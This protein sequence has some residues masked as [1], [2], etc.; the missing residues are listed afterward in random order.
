MADKKTTQWGLQSPDATEGVRLVTVPSWEDA[1]AT[2]YNTSAEICIL[3]IS[4]K[5]IKP[6]EAVAENSVISSRVILVADSYDEHVR[7]WLQKVMPAAILIRPFSEQ[8]LAGLSECI[9]FKASKLG[10]T[11]SSRFV[12]QTMGMADKLLRYSSEGFVLI[13]GQ[14]RTVYANKAF[15]QMLGVTQ[16]EMVGKTPMDFMNPE[17]VDEFQ[18]EFSRRRRGKAFGRYEATLRTRDGNPLEVV[19]NALGIYS[20]KGKYL[21]SFGRISQKGAKLAVPEKKDFSQ[22]SQTKRSLCLL[23]N[24]LL[25]TLLTMKSQERLKSILDFMESFLASE[26]GDNE[27]WHTERIG[28]TKLS[29]NEVALCAMIKSGLTSD[30]IAEIFGISPKTVAFHRGKLR[31]KLGLTKRGEGLAAF[32]KNQG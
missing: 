10:T 30:Q 29:S 3:D 19:I 28:Q 5:T 27:W 9:S 23:L 16:N 2:L 22:L 18:E 13:D 31:Q 17:N 12:N 25:P 21:G 26:D 11:P 4:D 15:A 7:Q 1:I 24:S 14:G 32:L 20:E 6:P 8:Q